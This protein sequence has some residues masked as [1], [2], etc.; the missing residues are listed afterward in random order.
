MFSD[1]QCFYRVFQVIRIN[2]KLTQLHNPAQEK[3]LI[4]GQQLF[5][6]RGR[7]KLGAGAPALARPPQAWRGRPRPQP[8]VQ[9]YRKFRGLRVSCKIVRFGLVEL[10]IWPKQ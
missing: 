6:A 2:P 8:S 9:N 5:Y 4:S 3:T 10:Q 7:P 1:P